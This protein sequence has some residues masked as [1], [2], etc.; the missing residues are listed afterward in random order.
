M[1]IVHLGLE[2]ASVSQSGV[3]WE[4]APDG[5]DDTNVDSR[6]VGQVHCYETHV[7]DENVDETVGE[8]AVQIDTLELTVHDNVLVEP[9]FPGFEILDNVKHHTG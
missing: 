1:V 8:E 5:G 7:V 9:L 4:N 2:H 6:L 3:Q